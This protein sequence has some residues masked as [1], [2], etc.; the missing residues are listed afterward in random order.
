MTGRLV[1]DLVIIL[2]GIRS[3]IL[4][5]GA[6]LD[7]VA[8]YTVIG[9]RTSD[10]LNA[11]IFPFS[12]AK[13]VLVLDFADP[14]LRNIQIIWKEKIESDVDGVGRRSWHI[15]NARPIPSVRVGKVCESLLDCSHDTWFAP[16][17]CHPLWHIWH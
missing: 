6:V 10:N 17:T 9:G 12:P 14:K 15:W 1:F 4:R 11:K 7:L 13:D 5:G 3:P 2:S 16:I 8:R